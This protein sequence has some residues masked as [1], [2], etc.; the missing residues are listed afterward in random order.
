MLMWTKA[1]NA[2][3]TASQLPGW[4]RF[5]RGIADPERIQRGV[6]RGL[7]RAA[8]TT[9]FGRERGLDAPLSYEEM[10]RRLP[11]TEWQNWE[12]LVER[13]RHSFGSAVISADCSRYEPT[14]GSTARRKWIPYSRRLLDEFDSAAAPWIFDLS[15]RFPGIL[16]GRHYWSLSWLPD[17]LRNAP[18]YSTDDLQLFPWWKRA[19][20]AG[21]MAVPAQVGLL[22]TLEESMFETVVKLAACR[23]LTFISVWSPTFAFELLRRLSRRRSEV[24]SA[25]LE[26]GESRAAAILDGWDGTICP[27]IT[28]EL[29]PH[30]ALVSAWDTSTAAR[31][32]KE[33]RRLFAHAR[34][35][36]KGVWATEGAVTIPVSGRYPAAV[37]SHFLEFQCLQSDKVVPLWE[38]REGME[39]QP[40]L[41][42]GSGLWRYRLADRLRVTGF[43]S[44]CPSLEFLGR[45]SS[46]DMVGEKVDATAAAELLERLGRETG[47]P[48]ISLL[49]VPGQ[50][51]ALE[52]PRYRVLVEGARG[53]GEKLAARAEDLLA[54][55]HHYRLARE[56]GQL[57]PVEALFREDA[58]AWLMRHGAV[59]EGLL[60][61]RKV[62]ALTRFDS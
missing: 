11:V 31:Y 16:R 26:R 43:L 34:F 2:L 18:G 19:V 21:T 22:P 7:L 39:V 12:E 3:T 55:H 35:Q 51:A 40:L 15:I 33:L 41:T 61:G 9:E 50:G 10:R 57:G 24:A 8:A 5:A 48:C 46:I 32:A 30:L 59:E 1:A 60:G 14:S 44:R 36:G 6:L 27:E 45:L 28:A 38:L 53:N 54:A 4:L 42:T 56:L 47:L 25:L 37:A 17:E 62:E 13:Q 20:M 49:A 58:T 52:L 23:E 29:W